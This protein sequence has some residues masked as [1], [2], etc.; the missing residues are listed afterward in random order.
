MESTS[1]ASASC[2]CCAE[3]IQ[4]KLDHRSAAAAAADAGDDDDDD[5]VTAQQEQAV[6]NGLTQSDELCGTQQPCDDDDADDDVNWFDDH[7]VCMLS[8]V[9]LSPH[10]GLGSCG[11]FVRIGPIC[12]LARCHKRRLNQ[13]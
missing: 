11:F 2:W 13:G 6:C 12:F 9:N 5:D 3:C 4:S 1:S 8:I 7:L 10:A